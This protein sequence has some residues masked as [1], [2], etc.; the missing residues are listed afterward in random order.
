[1]GDAPRPRDYAAALGLGALAL[2]A[3]ALLDRWL[4]PLQPFAPGFVAVTASVWFFGWRPA[5]LTALLSYVG[6][7]YLFAEP[8]GVVFGG[9]GPRDLA[10]LLTFMAACAMIIAIGNRARRAERALARAN[11]ELREM[12]ARK[13]AFL[14]ILSHELRN[15]VGVIANG[16]ATLQEQNTD[17]RLRPTLAILSRQTAH[18]RRLL[19]DLLDVGRIT[20]GRLELRTAQ[21]DIREC[22]K[23][24]V[25]ASQYAVA[26]KG[27]T[28]VVELPTAP[29]L[30]VV[31]PA[32]MLQVVSNL[33]DNASKYSPR[34]ARIEVR[35]VEGDGFAIE[36]A[37]D[38]P[39][40]DDEALPRLFDLFDQGRR[41]PSDGLGI[42]L[43]LCKHLVEMHGGQISAMRNLQGRGTTFRVRFC[44]GAPLALDTPAALPDRSGIDAR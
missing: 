38:G 9:S 10:A 5:T 41:S 24:A 32:R 23:H 44:S 21:A 6:A 43:G 40:I 30:A 8:R 16:A 2:L 17:P 7:A 39:G 34:G 13:N 3:R 27:Q 37:D 12:D 33:L 18:I 14:A 25:E 19:D 28:V 35:V 11:A 36:V 29:V 15:P 20:R 42:G 4:G 22:V 31:D 26:Q 1:M